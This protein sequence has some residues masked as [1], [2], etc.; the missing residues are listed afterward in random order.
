MSFQ[1]P[2]TIKEAI[3]N[4]R[5]KKYLLPSIQR[6]LVWST[7]QIEKLFDSLL[8]DYPVGSFLF[9]HVDKTRVTEFTFYEF[10]K[11]Y[12][13]R[14][15]K[16]NAKADLNGYDD[17]TAVL[18]GQQR[19]TSLY[20]GLMG[21]Y[22][23]KDKAKRWNN[24]LAFPKRYLYLNLLKK[25]TDEEDI[26]LDLEY[27]FSFLTEQEAKNGNESKTEEYFWFKVSDI[28]DFEKHS[29][30]NS[31]LIKNGLL[32]TQEDK[33]EFASETLFK[34]YSVVHEQP[35]IN[36][37]LEK[38][39][40]LDKVLNI[41]VRINSGG[42]PLSYADLLLSIAS[43]SW[44]KRDAREDITGFVD[45]LSDDGEGFNFN[46]DF[47]LKTCLALSDFP[48]IAFK[49]DNFN[50]ANMRT[51]EEN[52]DDITNSLRLTVN[53]IESFGYRRETLISNNA[54]IPIA[55][56]L[57][58][59][60]NPTNFV[61]SSQFQEDRRRIQ[62]WLIASLLKRAFSGQPDGV[63]RPIR[64]IIGKS[65][66]TF[67]LQEIIDEFKGKEKSIIFS[68][69]DVEALFDNWY[70]SA[71]TFS[72]LAVF[73]PTLDF[74]NRFHIDHI[75]PKSL[76]NRK[77]L[78]ARGLTEEQCLDFMENVD[79]L[80]N[81][82]LLEGIPNIEKSNKEFKQWL[83][84][85]FPDSQARSAYMERNF[86]PDIDLNLENFIEFFTERTKLMS[87]RFPALIR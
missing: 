28:L 24:N 37:F 13:E 73:Y 44:K 30:I 77:T 74:K 11:S 50:N 14:D 33:A 22:A 17:I 84:E 32:N 51:I 20:I 79:Y 9:W 59:K 45:E 53:L 61:E 34:L 63:L 48:N 19:L 25:F 76:F 40:D 72:T 78:L 18:D 6:E 65:F 68:E 56:Y 10:I 8:R 64:Q 85:T 75:F 15:S 86:I 69:D 5:S 87:S 41:F 39:G 23:K 42:T 7:R 4:V 62:K 52:W 29:E 66:E 46:R 16:H 1:T 60:G 80:A 12:H 38:Q 49:V 58:K 36:Y 81:L 31:F 26:D 43:A 35:S 21:S 71:Y 83:D 67:P 70:G 82:Q 54:L 55:Y 3:E 2:I 57:Q 27:D 47:V